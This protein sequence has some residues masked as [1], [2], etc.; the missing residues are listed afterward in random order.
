MAGYVLGTGSGLLAAAAVYYT[1][2]TSLRQATDSLQNDLHRSTALLSDSFDPQTP[3]APSSYVGPS[4]PYTPRFTDTLRSRWNVAISRA[5]DGVRETDWAAMGLV[6]VDETGKVVK[7]LSTQLQNSETGQAVAKAT[8]TSES[9]SRAADRVSEKAHR[10]V[11]DISSTAQK[12]ASSVSHGLKSLWPKLTGAVQE[13]EKEAGVVSDEVKKLVHKGELEAQ[14][15]DRLGA[16]VVGGN[17][18]EESF[19]GGTGRWVRAKRQVEGH[20]EGRLV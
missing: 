19:T 3:P 10:M 13:V 14:E 4:Y 5:F 20:L 7:R 2:S 18:R 15:L 16:G 1:L 6:V 9:V 12:E 11:D 8:P 17:I